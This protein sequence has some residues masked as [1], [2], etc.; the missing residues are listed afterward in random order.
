MIAFTAAV[1]GGFQIA[2]YDSATRSSQILTSV[3]E[4]AV[5]PAWLN[6]GRHLVFTQR[7]KGRMRLML[8]DTETKKVSALHVPEFGDASSAT[9]VY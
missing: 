7:Q 6:D 9:F 5:E 3:Q 8:L 1:G 4:S 2:L